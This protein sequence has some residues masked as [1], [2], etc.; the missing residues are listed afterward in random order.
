M[1]E[2]RAMTPEER[3]ISLVKFV[4]HLAVECE[5]G[6]IETECREDGELFSRAENDTRI[7]KWC[8]D[9]LSKIG[10]R[11]RWSGANGPEVVF[12]T[13]DPKRV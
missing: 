10:A 11:V 13:D 4:D 6:I 2:G 8:R 12:N 5:S 1:D 9:A 7:A 3:L